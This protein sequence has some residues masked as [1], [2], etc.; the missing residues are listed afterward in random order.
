MTEILGISEGENDGPDWLL[1]GQLKDGRFFFL[2]AGCDYTGWD[3]Q[4]NGR[5]YVA[6]ERNLIE[7]L[8]ITA[9]ERQRMAA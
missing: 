4:A 7:S 9:E 6:T 3:C 2:S 5:S 8:V 1:F